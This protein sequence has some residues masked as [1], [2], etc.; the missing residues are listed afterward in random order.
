MSDFIK[1]PFNFRRLKGLVIDSNLA[2]QH[3]TLSEEEFGY[4]VE[5]RYHKISGRA[6]S[7]LESKNFICNESEVEIRG[8]VLTS[9]YASRVYNSL[10]PPS[11]FLVVPTLRCD[12]DCHYCQ[13]SRVSRSAIGYD[14]E[15]KHISDILQH[16]NFLS[17]EYVKIEFQGGE[18]LL[19]FSFVKKFVT[20]AKE[21]LVD[22]KIEFVIATA[23]GPIDSDKLD[24]IQNNNIQ[25]SISLDGSELIHNKNRPSKEINSFKNTEDTIGVIQNLYKGIDVSALSTITKASLNTKTDIVDIYTKLDLNELFIRPLSPYGFATDTWSKLGYTAD[26]FMKFYEGVL[27]YIVKSKIKVVEFSA[28]LHLKRIFSQSTTYVDLKSPAGIVFGA[29]CFDYNGNIFGSD[30]SRMLWTTIKS[31]ELVLGKV[32][33]SPRE[34]YRNQ[35]TLALLKDTFIEVNPGC[36]DCAYS[37]YCGADP[38]HHL[39]TQGDLVGHKAKSFFCE[40]ETKMFDFI[41]NKYY[42]DDSYKKMFNSWLSECY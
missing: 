15:E 25:L 1:L 12:H 39:S 10:L 24:W 7:S 14:L 6:L 40:I 28:L 30:E 32:A 23:L 4:L 18:P 20:K 31:D 37:Q 29:V 8:R 34:T 11:L 33:N 36:S 21:E 2:G 38:V 9:K 26:E 17:K 13:V 19:N 3:Q 5:S 27:D 42:T 35:N 22:K 16:I 41:F